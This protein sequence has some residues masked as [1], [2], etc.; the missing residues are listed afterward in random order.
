VSGIKLTMKTFQITWTLLWPSQTRND[1]HIT[2]SST[3]LRKFPFTSD[4]VGAR[5]RPSQIVEL[6]SGI[7]S[8]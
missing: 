1:L 4:F 8:Y 2:I 3:S 7:E 6:L 5:D